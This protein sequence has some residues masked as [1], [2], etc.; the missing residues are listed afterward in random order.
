MRRSKKG[1]S[2]VEYALGIGCVSAVCMV[3]L[4]FLGHMSGDIFQSVQSSVNYGGQPGNHG[5]TD[6]GTL[7]NTSQTPWNIN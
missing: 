4:S 1:Q 3:S 2:L 5:V 6:P 7:V